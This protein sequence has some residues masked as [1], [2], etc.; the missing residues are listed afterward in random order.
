VWP[1]IARTEH[2]AESE[3]T[4]MV[5]RRPRLTDT[6][7]RHAGKRDDAGKAMWAQSKSGTSDSRSHLTDSSLSRATLLAKQL[8]Q[9]TR[10]CQ[11]QLQQAYA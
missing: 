7:N 9:R 8:P 4:G 11:L 6:S 5:L 1:S 10:H 3:L 2:Y